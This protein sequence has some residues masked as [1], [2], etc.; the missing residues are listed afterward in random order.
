M[1]EVPPCAPKNGKLQTIFWKPDFTKFGISL[2]RGLLIPN[3]R[4]PIPKDRPPMPNADSKRP[5]ADLQVLA[6]GGLQRIPGLGIARDSPGPGG[7]FSDGREFSVRLSNI[8]STRVLNQQVIF[9]DSGP[10]LK[11][12]PMAAA[13]LL[14]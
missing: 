9:P 14:N 7:R 13:A 12:R 10:R 4:P 5:F 8:S 1:P 3:V 11:F 6:K 2:A